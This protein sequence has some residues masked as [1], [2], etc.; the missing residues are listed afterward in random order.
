MD[1]FTLFFH[2]S[3]MKVANLPYS[4]SFSLSS[5]FCTLQSRIGPDKV[6]W[7]GMTEPGSHLWKNR[8]ICGL[9]AEFHKA[10]IAINSLHK[11]SA[12]S[13]CMVAVQGGINL[14]EMGESSKTLEVHLCLDGVDKPAR[15]DS[16]G[17]GDS[18]RSHGLD[19]FWDTLLRAAD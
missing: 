4:F 5:T 10:Q 14:P 19:L 12:N 16:C 9:F 7:S 13:D 6:H 8:C 3:V 2:L 15:D 11:S 17:N 1:C 18:H